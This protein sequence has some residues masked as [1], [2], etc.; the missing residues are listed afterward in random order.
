MK[1]DCHEKEISNWGGTWVRIAIQIFKEVLKYS[2]NKITKIGANCRFSKLLENSRKR[3]YS[4]IEEDKDPYDHTDM[5][6]EIT[7]KQKLIED[8]QSKVDSLEK[9]KILYLNDQVKLENLYQ[10][11]F[12]DSQEDPL[13]FKQ[14]EY[15]IIN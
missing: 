10:M 4:Q 13:L 8:L 1:E 9:E 14:K 3:K 2:F 15:E 6:K 11:C 12:I 7:K 5:K